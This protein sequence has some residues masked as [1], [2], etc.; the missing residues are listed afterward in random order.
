MRLFILVFTFLFV[1]VVQAQDTLF[2]KN[3]ALP[4]KSLNEALTYGI[5]ERDVE[6]PNQVIETKFTADK[7]IVSR[8]FYKD[9]D[10]RKKHGQQMFW[11]EHSKLSATRQYHND[12]L[13]GYWRE[14]T[15][16]GKLK[17][18]TLYYYGKLAKDTIYPP[19]KEGLKVDS[20][21]EISE[22]RWMQFN[23]L[24]K[25]CEN[26]GNR[27]EREFCS[28][29]MIRKFIIENTRK[30]IAIREAENEAKVQA[31]ITINERGNISNIRILPETEAPYPFQQEAIRVLLSLPEMIPGTRFGEKRSVEINIPV[32]FG[33]EY[34]ERVD[35]FDY[36]TI[37]S[38]QSVYGLM[39]REQ[40]LRNQMVDRMPIWVGCH[41]KGTDETEDGCTEFRLR[42][43]ISKNV[44]YPHELRIERP[45]DMFLVSFKV[46]EQGAVEILNILERIGGGNELMRQAAEDVVNSIPNFIPAKKDGK[47][48]P[49][50]F[51]VSVKFK[52]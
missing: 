36:N 28:S 52:Y 43:Y 20:N 42:R 27:D 6:K 16:H 2:Y 40:D 21:S 30:P 49:F 24:V 37:V 9:F 51:T 32:S 12:T 45:E 38:N 1:V 13:H 11:N 34:D 23:P 7:R 48:V 46:D 39:I 41:L 50:E 29:S 5:L 3:N 15:S 25:G 4:A 35:Y 8:T 44:Q 14:Y 31:S 19:D 18:E 22:Y 33:V 17:R 26:I 47:P 10:N